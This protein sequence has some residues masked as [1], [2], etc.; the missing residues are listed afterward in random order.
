MREQRLSVELKLKISFAGLS[1]LNKAAERCQ[2]ISRMAS[3]SFESNSQQDL[4]ITYPNSSR[5]PVIN[6]ETLAYC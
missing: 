3:H 4:N 1:Y 5:N 2:S 6:R